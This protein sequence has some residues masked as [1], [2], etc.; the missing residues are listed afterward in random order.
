MSVHRF[1]LDGTEQELMGDRSQERAL[2][3][4]DEEQSEGIV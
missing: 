3:R 1:E 4:K 2:N